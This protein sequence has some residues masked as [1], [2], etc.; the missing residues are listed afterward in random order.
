MSRSVKNRLALLYGQYVSMEFTIHRVT[1][2][3]PFLGKSEKL[4]TNLGADEHRSR[5]TQGNNGVGPHAPGEH[6]Y[7]GCNE[8][9]DTDPKEYREGVHFNSTG[10]KPGADP[11]T[12]HRR[13]RRG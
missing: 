7:M 5:S 6:R 3:G 9:E 1:S 2:E 11:S 8:D 12:R 4:T 13:P 10:E